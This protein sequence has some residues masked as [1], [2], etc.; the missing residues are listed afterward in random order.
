MRS[1]AANTQGF[2][3]AVRND[4]V[5]FATLLEQQAGPEPHK[6][7]TVILVID[8]L[9]PPQA[10][11]GRGA[12]AGGGGRGVTRLTQAGL[13]V[14]DALDPPQMRMRQEAGGMALEFGGGGLGG[15]E[16]VGA[17]QPAPLPQRGARGPNPPLGNRGLVDRL[18][19]DK[20]TDEV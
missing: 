20:R 11:G 12:G 17:E 6:R 7:K 8:R 9:P 10:L 14:G 4:E 18:T 15:G 5:R 19:D 13:P 3:Y 2:Q 16:R 1:V